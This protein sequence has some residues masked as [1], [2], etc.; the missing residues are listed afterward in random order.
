MLMI[1]S[2]DLSTKRNDWLS[3]IQVDMRAGLRRIPTLEYAMM[4]MSV[5]RGFTLNIRR[6][7]L[8]YGT[9]FF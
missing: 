2:A 7:R 8:L 4:R 9:E 5:N 6:A 1:S 3:C